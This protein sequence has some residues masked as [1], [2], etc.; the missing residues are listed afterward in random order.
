MPGFSF[1]P[2]VIGRL[3][4]HSDST[5]TIERPV[6]PA[7]RQGQGLIFTHLNLRRNP[8][9]E[10][11]QDDRPGVAVVDPANLL[12][13]LR[14]PSFALQVVGEQEFGPNVRAIEARL[15]DCFQNLRE[16]QYV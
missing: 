9:G 8:F 12:G 1:P 10:L 14:N 6:L 4:M 2:I 11:A 15:Y 5:L 7:A 16:I 3:V 13:E